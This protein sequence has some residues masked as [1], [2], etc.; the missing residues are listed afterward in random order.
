MPASLTSGVATSIIEGSAGTSHRTAK[1][2]H[3]DSL[4]VGGLGAVAMAWRVSHGSLK[5]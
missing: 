5:P 4:R 3:G 2:L 1:R